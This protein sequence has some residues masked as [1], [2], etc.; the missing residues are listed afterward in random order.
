MHV[1]N[2]QRGDDKVEPM[3][4][5]R[6]CDRIFTARDTCELRSMAQ[7]ESL[8]LIANEFVEAAVFFKQ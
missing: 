1:V 6:E 8:V 2:V 5:F 4:L 3:F 7:I